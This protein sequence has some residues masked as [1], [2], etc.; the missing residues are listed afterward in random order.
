MKNKIMTLLF[1]LCSAIVFS[2]E[3]KKSFASIEKITSPQSVTYTFESNYFIDE[4]KAPLKENRLKHFFPDI[5]SITINPN[6]QI[7]AVSFKNELS[8][9]NILKLIYHFQYKTYE[10]N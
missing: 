6:N 7:V 9:E 3:E 10:I 5:L 1:I 4:F 2:Q 8:K